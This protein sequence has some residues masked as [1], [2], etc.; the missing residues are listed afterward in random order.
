MSYIDTE[1]SDALGR[2]D[3]MVE[4]TAGVI[5]SINV[6]KGVYKQEA[7]EQLEQW[8]TKSTELRLPGNRVRVEGSSADASVAQTGD[9]TDANDDARSLFADDQK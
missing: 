8:G 4:D 3:L 5:N 9:G 6:Q 7:L 2:V 1:V